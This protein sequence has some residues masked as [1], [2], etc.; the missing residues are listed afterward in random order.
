MN[1]EITVAVNKYRISVFAQLHLAYELYYGIESNIAAENARERSILPYRCSY[2]KNH[3]SCRG[4][5][6]R[7]GVYSLILCLCGLIPCA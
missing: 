5:D 3:C 1:K 6:I 2:R 4:I 7:S